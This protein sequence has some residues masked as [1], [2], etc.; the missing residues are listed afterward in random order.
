MSLLDTIGK[1]APRPPIITICGDAG[2]G[3][4]SLAAKFPNPI[5]IR[6]ED[7]LARISKQ[8]DTPLAFPVIQEP[9]ALWDQLMALI[10][11]DHDYSTLIIDSVTKLEE[12]FVRDILDTDKR[13]KGINQALGG[14]GNGPSAVAAM[15]GRVRKAC[16]VLNDKKKMAIIFIAHA[17]LENMKL[18]DIDDYQRY[19]LRMMP[20]GIPH[21]VDDV[22]LVGYVRLASALRGGDD[23]RKKVISDG[24]REFV[25]HA[26]AASVS[27]NG[28]GISEPIL[29]PEGSNPL[30]VAL[31]IEKPDKAE[32][33]KETTNNKE[34]K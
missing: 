25:C 29:F 20:K 12:I 23:E 13:A 14:Y 34:E 15:H 2:T 8:V 11:E 31:G 7:G 27:K 6:A 19:S 30:G 4:T 9:K 32:T 16:G 18:P 24:T 21:Y 17:D 10:N 28:L 1:P 26:T 5:V 3:K 22:D 33:N